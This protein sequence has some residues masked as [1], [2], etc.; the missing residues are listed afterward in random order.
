[1][2]N[3]TAQLAWDAGQY[4]RFGDERTQPARDLL[5]RVPLT[6]PKRVIDL[7]CGP[8][9]STAMV[10]ERFPGAEVTGV[11]SSP[12]ML[13]QARA[14]HPTWRW[15]EADIAAWSPDGAHDLIFSNAAL[16]WVPDHARLFP[17]LF[18]ALPPG[19]VLAVQMPR[20]FAAP[21]HAL[22]RETAADPRWSARLPAETRVFP[23]GE[24][25]L[26]Y[27]LLAPRA[28][29]LDIFEIEYLHVLDGPEGVVEW[30]KGTGL[31]PFLQRLD[32]AEQAPFLAAY[33]D[34]LTKAYP[35]RADGKVLLPFRRLFLLASR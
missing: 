6:A 19:G 11:D 15:I 14:D 28:S 5:A 20:N 34:R 29:R 4:L 9:N 23:V 16:Q 12:E 21:T 30:M 13:A 24:P 22:M 3:H 32:P 27:D 26:Y 33:L 35:R 10:A 31:R 17:A 8:G 7:G 2:G 18:D 1:M 25:G